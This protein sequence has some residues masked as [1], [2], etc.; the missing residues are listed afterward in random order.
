M[1]SRDTASRARV[2]T[3]PDTWRKLFV[4]VHVVAAVGLI[5]TVVTLA[6]L[7]VSGLRGADP[8]SVFPPAHMVDAWLVIPL[9]LVALV[10]G[11]AQAVIGS[12]GLTTH[13]WVAFKLVSTALAAVIVV[14]VLEPRLALSAEAAQAG[15]SFTTRE[16]LPLTVAPA[17]AALVL[18]ANVVLGLFKP[19]LRVSRE[20]QQESA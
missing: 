8:L 7:G 12:W 14:F 2:E 9:A 3:S 1:Q 6:G 17:V 13:R 19:S 4:T 16:F 20:K 5:G 11:I 18:C 15:N 10:T